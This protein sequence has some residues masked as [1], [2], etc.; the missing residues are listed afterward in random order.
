MRGLSSK[1]SPSLVFEVWRSEIP[2]EEWTRKSDFG[3]SEILGVDCDAGRG[4]ISL[5]SLFAR[6]RLFC[7]VMIWEKLPCV[8]ARIW[9]VA[10]LLNL[11]SKLARLSCLVFPLFWTRRI[12]GVLIDFWE[13]LSRFPL[14]SAFSVGWSLG[15]RVNLCKSVVCDPLAELIQFSQLKVWFLRFFA[16]KR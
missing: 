8:L 11:V 16:K 5:W 3:S 13:K 10:S 1:V 6:M 12:F 2:F 15:S 14:K 4:R 7:P 9:W